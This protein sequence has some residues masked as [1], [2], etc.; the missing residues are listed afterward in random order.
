[1]TTALL[2]RVEQK[3]CPVYGVEAASH[4]LHN[5]FAGC[6]GLVELLLRPRQNKRTAPE[7]GGG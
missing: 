2:S 7:T 6:E 5:W 3:T 1:M 4:F